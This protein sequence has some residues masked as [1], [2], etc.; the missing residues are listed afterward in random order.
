M[1]LD[2][3]SHEHR[4]QSVHNLTEA[5]RESILT[6]IE[7]ALADESLICRT[8]FSIDMLAEITGHN[9]RYVSHILNGR[10]GCNFRTLLNNLRMDIARRRIID[11][12]NYGHLTI[13]AIAESLG[14]KSNSGFVQLFRKYTGVTPSMFQKMAR[15]EQ[16]QQTIQPDTATTPNFSEKHQ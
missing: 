3:S 11:V 1:L 4:S 10:Y 9:T 5:K 6:A 2:N 13:Q 15:E 12:G 8:D 7:K 14:Y 16:S